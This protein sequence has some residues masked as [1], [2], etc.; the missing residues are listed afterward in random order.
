MKTLDIILKTHSRQADR[1]MLCIL[2]GLFAM[3]LA[4]SGLHDTLRWALLVGLPTA[5]LPTAMIVF[6]G[7]TRLLRRP[8]RRP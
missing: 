4:L 1:L 2:W 5:L 7:G 3:A 8:W 6:Y